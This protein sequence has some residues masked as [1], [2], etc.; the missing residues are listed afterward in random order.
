MSFPTQ[1]IYRFCTTLANRTTVTNAKR[2]AGFEGGEPVPAGQNNDLIG[3]LTD[4]VSWWASGEGTTTFVPIGLLNWLLVPSGDGGDAT[5]NHDAGGS[6]DQQD[7]PTLIQITTTGYV[8]ARCTIPLRPGK[9]TGVTVAASASADDVE[10]FLTVYGPSGNQLAS[11][12]LENPTTLGDYSMV[13]PAVEVPGHSWAVLNVML[14][15]DIGR[16][17]SINRLRIHWAAP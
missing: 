11:F 2:I 16:F 14:S 12:A 7:T 6:G 13:G 9:I 15:E 10:M 4:W 5:I 8:Y 3:R 17:A 1:A